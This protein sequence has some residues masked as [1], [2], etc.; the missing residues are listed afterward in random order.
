MTLKK[1][2]G[3]GIELQN[4]DENL[5]GYTPKELNNSDDIYCQR[6]FK[7]KHYGKYYKNNLKR[8][9]YS[10]EVEKI[11]E[12]VN[13]VIPVFDIID[14]EGSF[15][16]KILD[17]LR[18]KES[19]V[20]I[21]KLDLIPDEKHPSEVADW[22]KKR[23]EEESI[24]PLDIAIVSSKNGYGING[25]I[26]KIK[27]F[28][29]E[30]VEAII[31]GVTNVGKSSIINK[32]IGKK[33]NT[34]SKFPGTT[35][36]NIENII[37]FT[38]IK[39][40]DTPGLILENR[41]SDILCDECS[42]K[43]IPE[44]EISRKTFKGKNNRIILIENIIKIKILNRDDLRPIFSI[45]ASK[46]INFHETNLEKAKELCKNKFFTIPC[47]KCFEKNPIK[48]KKMELVINS[49]EELVF[50]GL[51]WISV[52]RGP[53]KILLEIPEKIEPIIRKSFINPKRKG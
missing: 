34:V 46:N 22:V 8:E 3:C 9:D 29:P 50:K 25:I 23:L 49:G 40:Y 32:L 44:S 10:R 48:N 47:E 24:V 16:Y 5:Q 39:I 7:L 43:T 33:N 15:D 42:Q 30:G 41:I 26:K 51:A 20:V 13:L 27:H 12:K 17:I 37:P 14:F 31:I 4:K 36:K 28:Y 2:I 53:L 18:E 1:C 45:Y 38:N 19:I 11:L 52:K 35:L 6:C 21:N